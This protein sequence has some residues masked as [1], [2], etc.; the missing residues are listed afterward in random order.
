MN[1]YRPLRPF[2]VLLSALLVAALCLI[3]TMN[4][5][6]QVDLHKQKNIRHVAEVYRKIII[7]SGTVGIPPLII[8][9]EPNIINAWTDGSSIV[10]TTGIINFFKNDDEL[11]LVLGHELAHYM[12]KDVGNA[13]MPGVILEHHAD[14]MGAFIMQRAGYDICK[15]A[16]FFKHL[17][18]YAGDSA[19]SET[20]PSH[21]FRYDQLHL[22]SCHG[23]YN[24]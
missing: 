7:N 19:Y 2:T 20:H 5:K 6:P 9:D 12:K 11:A 10:L 13:Y 14:L 23:S 15:G 1:I 8:V 21:A 18:E 24:E 22:P 16:E 17:K 3:N 4:L